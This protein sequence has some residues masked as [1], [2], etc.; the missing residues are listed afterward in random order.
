MAHDHHHDAHPSADSDETSG[1]LFF[2][3]CVGIA[4]F[5][6]LE[7]PAPAHSE[8]AASTHHGAAHSASESSYAVEPAHGSDKGHEAEASAALV[9]PSKDAAVEPPSLQPLG[10]GDALLVQ[11]NLVGEPL[12]PSAPARPTAPT[13]APAKTAPTSPLA[14]VQTPSPVG[15][16]AE[17]PPVRIKVLPPTGNA[18]PPAAAAPSTA[19][20]PQGPAAPP[21]TGSA[22]PP[23]V[24]APAPTPAAPPA[25][26]APQAPASPAA[27]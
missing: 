27:P 2:V 22:S 24:T 17:P 1:P 11:P 3:A 7:A 23:S 6:L 15:G 10:S 25:P 21:G 13:A 8:K 12:V 20:A 18:S 16:P 5:G 19:R 4:L 26:A 14:P 9:E